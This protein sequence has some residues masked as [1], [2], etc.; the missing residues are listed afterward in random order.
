MAG[1][2]KLRQGLKCHHYIV[3]KCEFE[4]INYMVMIVYNDIMYITIKINGKR[5]IFL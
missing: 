5:Q 3:K 2:K 4:E 1:C